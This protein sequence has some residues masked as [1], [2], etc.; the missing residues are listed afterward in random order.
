MACSLEGAELGERLAEI[1]ALGGEALLESER[2]DGHEL[3]WFR[4]DPE[5]RARLER[6]VEAERR[7]CAF[8]DFDLG[9]DGGRLRLTISAPPEGEAF[10]AGLAEAFRA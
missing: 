8:L 1:G 4:A 10:S 5:V 9:E 3:L 7:C 6:V 2:R